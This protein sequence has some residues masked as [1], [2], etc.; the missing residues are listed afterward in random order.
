MNI[1]MQAPDGLWGISSAFRITLATGTRCQWWGDYDA[2]PVSKDSFRLLPATDSV[3][4]SGGTTVAI[5]IYACS[6]GAS[7]RGDC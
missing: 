6:F 7:S 4:V 1:Y 5:R 3:T 2:G